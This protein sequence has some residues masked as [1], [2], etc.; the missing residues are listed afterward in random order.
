MKTNKKHLIVK[1]SVKMSKEYEDV[2]IK[3]NEEVGKILNTKI[4]ENVNN[5]YKD[6]V[7]EYSFQYEYGENLVNELDK[8]SK[9]KERLEK[10]VSISK[11]IYDLVISLEN[12]VNKIKAFS[13]FSGLK[14]FIY[15][16]KISGKAIDRNDKVI[17]N[18][19]IILDKYMF[20]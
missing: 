15:G 20:E 9:D 17:Y 19:E 7:K 11:H 6:G 5:M 4:F 18:E 10:I 3:L 8:L 2:C 14:S 13:V 1:V 16:C 12:L